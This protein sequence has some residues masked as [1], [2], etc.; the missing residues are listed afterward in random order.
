MLFLADPLITEL[1]ITMTS[2]YTLILKNIHTYMCIY[3]VMKLE[4]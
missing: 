2:M 3:R 4:L 1:Y